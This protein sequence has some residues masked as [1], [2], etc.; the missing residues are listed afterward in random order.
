MEISN[1]YIR[2]LV[3]GEGSFTFS[4]TRKKVDGTRYK[5]PAFVISLH[6]R[7]KHLLQMIRDKLGLKSKIYYKIPM[8]NIQNAKTG[9]KYLS[10]SKPFL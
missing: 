10:E 3:E 4:T 2:G 7:D 8:V 1:E 6:I 9:V 5:L